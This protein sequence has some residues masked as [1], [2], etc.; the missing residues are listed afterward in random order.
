MRDVANTQTFVSSAPTLFISGT[1]DPNAPLS[2]VEEVRQGFLGSTSVIVRGGWHE[3][4]PIPGVRSLVVDFFAGRP[5]V[6]Q[7]VDGR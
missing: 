4:L 5:L 7:F 1:L 3:T 2:A 6:D